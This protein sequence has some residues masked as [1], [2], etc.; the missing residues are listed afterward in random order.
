MA[1]SPRKQEILLPVKT[2]FILFT[3]VAALLANLLPWQGVLF[4]LRPDFAAVVL[5]YWCVQQP[6]KAGIGAAFI[7]GLTM[8]V[9]NGN[10]LGQHALAYVV[11]AYVGIILHRRLQMFN[12]SQQML[13]V[14]P[15]LLISQVIILLVRL[16]AGANFPGWGYFLASA[17]GAAL[18][19]VLTA[20]LKIPQR[21]RT[22][23]NAV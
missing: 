21:P 9:A 4:W 17:S 3:L 19:P 20:L 6:R 13:N 22:D 2:G 14:I 5:L 11:M 10:L 23:P 15:L 18:W 12:L 8:D 16:M 7:L 1:D